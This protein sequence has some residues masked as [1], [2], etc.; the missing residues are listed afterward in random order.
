[1]TIKSLASAG[2]LQPRSSECPK[3]LW[4]AGQSFSV[5]MVGLCITLGWWAW[6]FT[7]ASEAV[8]EDCGKSWSLSVGAGGGTEGQMFVTSNL[9][10]RLGPCLWGRRDV[11]CHGK[12]GEALCIQ[13]YLQLLFSCSRLSGWVQA[14]DAVSGLALPLN[15]S[16]FR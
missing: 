1:M 13:L 2:F 8:M 16:A 11:F 12:W 15:C 10:C 3:F 9:D 7:W 6:S 14:G 4:F 5:I